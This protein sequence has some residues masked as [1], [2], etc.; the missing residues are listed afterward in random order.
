M[1]FSLLFVFDVLVRFFLFVWGFWLV[2]WFWVGVGG[3]LC[4]FLLN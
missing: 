2:G 1:C 3:G 4:L